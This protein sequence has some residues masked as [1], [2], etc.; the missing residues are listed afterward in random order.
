MTRG[1]SRRYTL[2]LA[3]GEPPRRKVSF[4]TFP[5]DFE[6][7]LGDNTFRE[8]TVLSD[9]AHAKTIKLIRNLASKPGEVEATERAMW[10][11]L[12]HNLTVSGVC[13]AIC[14]WI[15]KKEKIEKGTTDKVPEHVG[16]T[17]Y[18]M[19][20]VVMERDHF[21]VKV[22]IQDPDES[23]EAL[24]IISCHPVR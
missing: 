6:D 23:G 21:Y 11:L 12:S 13:H 1:H 16:E 17:H 18:V 20:P 15:D 5:I 8:A 2:R 14:D 4:D 24:Q 9:D 10:D 7:W 22:T 3:P 19:K